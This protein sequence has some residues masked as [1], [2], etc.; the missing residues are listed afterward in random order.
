MQVVQLARTDLPHLEQYVRQ[1]G[2]SYMLWNVDAKEGEIKLD[3]GPVEKKAPPAK[4]TEWTLLK[5]TW[6]GRGKV[7][8]SCE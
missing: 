6:S 2:F 5:A 7:V 4:W 8:L 3:D 1:S